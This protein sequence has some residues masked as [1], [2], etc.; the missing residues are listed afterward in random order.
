MRILKRTKGNEE[1]YYLQH[2]FR[3]NGK[4][5]TNEK[6]LGKEIPPEKELEKLKKAML[7]EKNLELN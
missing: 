4:V 5:I 2:S 3:E 7:K 6:Y 1:F